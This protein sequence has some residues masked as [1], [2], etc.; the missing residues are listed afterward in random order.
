M[1]SE[2]PLNIYVRAG[3][4][5]NLNELAYMYFETSWSFWVPWAQRAAILKSYDEIWEI[6]KS[7]ISRKQAFFGGLLCT[8]PKLLYCHSVAPNMLSNMF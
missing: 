3:S 8:T 6:G 4:Q 2:T 1:G 5:C 7:S